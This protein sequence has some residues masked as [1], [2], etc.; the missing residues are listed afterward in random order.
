VHLASSLRL[1]TLAEVE[2]DG[3]VTGGTALNFSVT[4]SLTPVGEAVALNIPNTVGGTEDGDLSSPRLAVVSGDGDVTSSTAL[5]LHVA[6][7]LT[8]VGEAVT[9]DVPDTVG[10]TPDGNLRVV[11]TVVVSRN[12][13][14]TSSTALDLGVAASLTPVGGTVTLD[15]PNTVGGTEDGNA[16]TTLTVVIS[17]H[18]D[19]TSSTALDLDVTASLTPVSKSGT[20]DVPGT[21]GG[22]E[23]SDA[24]ATLTEVVSRNGDITSSTALDLDVAAGGTPVAITVTLD[25]PNTVGGTEDGVVDVTITEVVTCAWKNTK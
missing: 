22:T 13:D 7:G 10:R 20:L 3:D 15:V 23:D 14:I 17:G 11:H 18:G 4:L 21:V 12:G 8:P 19:I 9:L 5:D 1:V 6:S 2:G 16:G 25:V 24:E